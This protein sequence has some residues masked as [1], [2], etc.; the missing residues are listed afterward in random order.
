MLRV[1]IEN[2]NTPNINLHI[3]TYG[4][5]DILLLYIIFP[6]FFSP[7]VLVVVVV[8]LVVCISSRFGVLLCTEKRKA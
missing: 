5:D 2:E 3:N 1:H 8:L 4:K 6:I 7:P